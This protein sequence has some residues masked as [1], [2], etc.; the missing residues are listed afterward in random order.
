LSVRRC[1][2]CILS[3]ALPGISF[4]AEGICSVC[5]DET[6]VASLDTAIERARVQVLELFA[7]RHKPYDAIVCNSGGKD[8]SYTLM[9]AV[10]KYGLR[11]LSF[12]LDNGFLAPMAFDNIRRVTDALG[13][14]QLTYQPSLPFFRRVIR[15][16]ATQPIYHEQT[17][18]R[19]S[20]GCNSCIS[21]VNTMALRMALEKEI[22]FILAG[23]TLGQI[24]ANAIVFRN[25]FRFL[26]ESRR[27]SLARLT[28]AVGPEVEDYYGIPDSVLDRVKSYPHNINLLCLEPL[29]EDEIVAQVES[30]GWRK[31]T[32]VDGCSSNCELN[33]FNNYVHERRLGFSPYELELSLLTRMGLMSRDE[34]L[35]KIADNPVSRLSHFADGLGMTVEERTS[36]GLNPDSPRG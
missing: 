17:L 20:A 6:A 26:A 8:S 15:A 4:D 25:H 34:A 31:P 14:E 13:V 29:R 12:T 32:G 33:T 35:H 5:R 18:T 7:N 1:R 9:L 28:Q 19:I 11:V 2:R 22:P 24:P 3:S 10:R 16:T 21:L 30:L 23:F 27:E 36:I